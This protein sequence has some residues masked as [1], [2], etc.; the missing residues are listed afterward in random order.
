MS[1]ITNRY[2]NSG[3]LRNMVMIDPR[4]EILTEIRRLIT[5]LEFELMEDEPRELHL[6]VQ[7]GRI[8]RILFDTFGIGES[9]NEVS[10]GLSISQLEK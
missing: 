4:Q 5:V 7:S 1:H 6:F 8:A 2:D 10:N 9:R 3:T